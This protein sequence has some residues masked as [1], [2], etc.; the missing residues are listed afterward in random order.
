MAHKRS[1]QCRRC[2]QPAE[3]RVWGWAARG[4]GNYG[5]YCKEHADA[6][7]AEVTKMEKAREEIN[8]GKVNN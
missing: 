4:D 6:K 5:I 2:S 8:V 7:V 1:L 3:Y